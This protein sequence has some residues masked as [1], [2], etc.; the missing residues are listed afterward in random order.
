MLILDNVV[1]IKL[2][3]PE[4][5]REILEV[6]RGFLMGGEEWRNENYSRLLPVY[7]LAPERFAGLLV[8][9]NQKLCFVDLR[10]SATVT[11]T[12]VA[13]RNSYS[14]FENKLLGT[15]LSRF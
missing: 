1:A 4:F 12:N 6:N 7:I 10:E 13:L 8:I 3:F 11:G 2:D 9:F 14:T 15:S 5:N